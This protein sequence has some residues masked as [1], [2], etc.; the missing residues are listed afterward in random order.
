MRIQ[1]TLFRRFTILAMD[2]IKKKWI[3]IIKNDWKELWVVTTKLIDTLFYVQSRGYQ[4]QSLEPLIDIWEA[5]FNFLKYT[6][7]K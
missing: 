1:R 6:K 2:T 7:W 3:Q 4:L 5:E